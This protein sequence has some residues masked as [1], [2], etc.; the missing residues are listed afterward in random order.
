MRPPLGRHDRPL[1]PQNSI[2]LFA[3]RVCRLSNKTHAV[4]NSYSLLH[5]LQPHICR[6]A[7]PVSFRWTSGS[8]SR[9][10][11]QHILYELAVAGITV[12]TGDIISLWLHQLP[13]APILDS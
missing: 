11:I 12:K 6:V 3:C 2:G 8:V 1:R 10:A 13:G 7:R 4:E 5:N 9:I